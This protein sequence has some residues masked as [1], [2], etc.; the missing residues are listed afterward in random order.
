LTLQLVFSVS[1]NESGAVTHSHSPSYSTHTHIRRL[2]SY[3]LLYEG[4]TP[5]ERMKVIISSQCLYFFRDSP[6]EP[7]TINAKFSLDDLAEC[8]PAKGKS[9]ESSSGFSMGATNMYS[10]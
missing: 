2:V 3:E 5:A 4:T 8:R 1:H 6:P 10:G 7:S 9:S